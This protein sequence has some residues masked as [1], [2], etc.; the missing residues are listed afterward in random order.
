MKVVKLAAL[1]TGRLYP[2]PPGSIPGTLFCWR[3]SRPQ[4]HSAA[5]RIMSVKNSNDSIGN[6]TRD[7]PACNAVPQPTAPPRGPTCGN[8]GVIHTH[9]H[10]HT[11]E[12]SFIQTTCWPYYERPKYSRCTPRPLMSVNSSFI[13]QTES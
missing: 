7:L 4:G 13:A 1:R 3:L 11:H 5:G 12:Y 8:T 9:T 2:A 10:T 6:R